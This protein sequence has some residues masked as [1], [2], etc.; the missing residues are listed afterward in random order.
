M[1]HLKIE[2]KPR[3][4]TYRRWIGIA[5]V[6][7]LAPIPI[8]VGLLAATYLGWLPAGVE[9]DH[10]LLILAGSLAVVVLAT[11]MAGRRFRAMMDEWGHGKVVRWGVVEN[12]L[13]TKDRGT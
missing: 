2:R 13:L 11:W 4:R 6:A 5:R 3:E 12:D 10:L 1:P 9:N 7:Q 8:M